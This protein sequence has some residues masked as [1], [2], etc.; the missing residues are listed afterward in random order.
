[1]G[2]RERVLPDP[3]TFDLSDPPPMDR[4]VVRLRLAGNWPLVAAEVAG[5]SSFSP[6]S[7]YPVRWLG[8]A[9]T[10]PGLMQS[11]AGRRPMRR[12]RGA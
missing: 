5:H 2:R 12:P 7:R 8:S 11:R 4:I 10:E 9:L 3:G 1:V 6:L